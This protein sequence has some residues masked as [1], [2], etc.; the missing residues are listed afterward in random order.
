MKN[1]V[2]LDSL[3]CAKCGSTP[4]VMVSSNYILIRC[5]CG[6]KTHFYYLHNYIS[7]EL[8][9]LDALEEWKRINRNLKKE[10]D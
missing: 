5:S 1:K 9:L 3:P 6:L 10:D 8:A 7:R 4:T 2:L